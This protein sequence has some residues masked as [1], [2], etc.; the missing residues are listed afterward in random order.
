MRTIL[1]PVLAHRLR[2]TGS[3]PAWLL[4]AW[5]AVLRRHAGAARLVVGVAADLR[6]HDELRGC[7]GPLTAYLPVRADGDLALPLAAHVQALDSQL[8]D[9]ARRAEWFDW[10]SA[11]A[12]SV[13]AGGFTAGFR[14]GI[15][16]EPWTG[17]AGTVRVRAVDSR[18]DRYALRLVAAD[19]G[20]RLDLLLEYDPARVAAELAADLLGSV[21]TL[22]ADGLAR[23]DQPPAALDLLS[24]A[25][26]S[27]LADAGRGPVLALPDAALPDV[28]RAAA[29]SRPDA[30]AVRSGATE[31]SYAE[32]FDRVDRLAG[33]LR[34]R[35]V[36]LGD[37]VG[38]HLPRGVDLLVGLLGVLAAGAAYVY[39]E[40]DQP[41]GRLAAL[42][43]DSGARLV[44]ATDVAAAS[45]LGV[46]VLPPDAAGPVTA[47]VPVPADAVAY[48]LYTSG[49]TGHPK[50]VPVPHRGLVNYLLGIGGDWSMPGAGLVGNS[51]AFD[52]SL[53]ALFL[54]LLHGGT[55]VMAP[56]GRLDPVV[57]A[58]ELTGP[59]CYEL[60][61]ATPTLLRA[62][63]A[64]L[65]ARRAAGRPAVVTARRIAVGG[66]PLDAALV[67]AWSAVADGVPLLNYYGPTETVG[68][69]THGVADP[70]LAGPT[71]TVPLG[72]P[73]ANTTLAVLGADL[74]PVPVGV[75]GELAI[76]GAGLGLGYHGSPGRTA[77]RFVPEPAGPPGA[78]RYLTG[79]LVRR[80]PGD[81]LEFVGRA[82]EQVKIRGH[83][84]E[85][86]EVAAALAGHPAV[87][88][89][90]V[91]A[92]PGPEGEPAL[93]GYAVPER[94][95]PVPIDEL[96]GY[97][98]RRLPDFML[99][100]AVVWLSALPMTPGGK[101][102][103]A[104]LPDPDGDRPE[105]SVGFRE[106]GTEVERVLAEVWAEVLG[107]SR[108]GVDDNFFNLGGDSILSILVAARAARRGLKLSL[109]HFF[110]H[111][112]IAGMA[113]HVANTGPAEVRAAEGSGL[114]P[115][116][117]WFFE[118]PMPS[119]GHWNQG[120]LLTAGR[121]DRPVDPVVL[122]AAVTAVVRHHPALRSRF[123]PDE[124][125]PGGWRSTLAEEAHP[126][127]FRHVRVPDWPAGLAGALAELQEVDLATGPL[128]RVALLDGGASGRQRLALI[129]H[130][131]AVDTVSWQILFE[132]LRTAYRALRRETPVALPPPTLAPHVWGAELAAAAGLA[133]DEL[134]HWIAQSPPGLAGLP[135]DRPGAG[136]PVEADRREVTVELD[137]GRT[138]LL[139][140][141]MPVNTRVDYALLAAVALAVAEWTGR[142][143]LHVT[144]EGQGRAPQFV[145]GAEL[146]RSV[147]WFTS[148]FPMLLRLPGSGPLDALRA[149]REQ[150]H[151]V[152][153]EGLGYGVLRYLDPDRGARLAALPRPQIAVNYVG[154]T[155]AGAAPAADQP[156]ELLVGPA[157]ERLPALVHPSASR[158]R[159]WG[160]NA[161]VR[162]EVLVLVVDYA[163]RHY[164]AATAERLADRIVHHL[165]TVVD[166]AVQGGHGMLTPADFP[167]LSPNT[168]TLDRILA[169][170]AAHAPEP[171]SQEREA[172]A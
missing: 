28:I 56:P 41:T 76:G 90:A 79:D 52:L 152:P 120:W 92:R 104:A 121:A 153:H 7:R 2:A 112:T 8:A 4:A 89:A 17:G 48:L 114:T 57:L 53:P 116:Q 87:R 136:V 12:D 66:E 65:S 15:L 68:A 59:H 85:P 149:V 80:L 37:R 69:R 97:A 86:G 10:E 106:P 151:A 126:D 72:V 130:H 129:G 158:A 108:V 162:G 163:G 50:G 143:Q 131:L 14:Y 100:S 84:V 95:G 20:D 18:C 101:L 13:P 31:L 25:T 26:L 99:P 1:G 29:S 141:R 70:D 118:Q 30:A 160:V 150:V 74:R 109:R 135:I 144:V 156:D 33:A 49:S 78:R 113:P 71:G 58:D 51:A 147:G 82:D 34:Q 172:G 165:R 146:Y 117:H 24:P 123:T 54:P 164:E 122:A 21:G 137:A 102:D 5:Q 6:R 47:A 88:E 171:T 96:R 19:A 81:R 103:R 91:V 75:T 67:R 154:R 32:L 61:R 115:V 93:V 27:R 11:L 138:R 155:G 145:D 77:E 63:V 128:L 23:P 124:S 73:I 166:A 105:Q 142:P 119:R 110:E 22:L 36:R 64:E 3:A 159:L 45:A 35:G 39:L 132:D 43:A 62:L 127:S 139:L 134:D 168:A 98:G 125:A 83:R 55:V 157:P 140:R 133:A 38:V 170:A 42:V 94:S 44:V 60:V 167:A 16:P 161:A 148:L 111:Q 46:E 40:P 107:L 9:G 169:K